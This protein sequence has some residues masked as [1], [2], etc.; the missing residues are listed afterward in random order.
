MAIFTEELTRQTTVSL[1][2]PNSANTPMLAN[3]RPKQG[4]AEVETG[5]SKQAKFNIV[6]V[7]QV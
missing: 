5:A 2:F 3:T 1:Y 7:L 4:R 6:S